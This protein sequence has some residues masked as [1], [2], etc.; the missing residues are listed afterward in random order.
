M[1]SGRPCRLRIAVIGGGLAG[2]TLANALIQIPHLEI[3]VFES[4]PTFS[5]RGA[6]VGL[7]S[8]A[9]QALEQILPGRKDDLL[10]RA[11]AVPL[12]SARSVVGSGPNAGQ[13][14]VDLSGTDPGVIVHRASLLRELVAPLP[15]KSLHTNKSLATIRIKPVTNTV[16][17]TFQDGT[18]DEFDAVIGADGIFSSVRSYVLQDDA[19]RLAASPAGFWDCRNL[20]SLE[21]AKAV[22]GEELFEVDRQYGWVGDGGFLMH[23]V[24][25]NRTMVQCV[26]S[27]VE[28]SPTR[29]RK[30][31]LTRQTLTQTLSSW[32]DGPIAKGMI[33]LALE[34][35]DL[36][37]YSQWEHKATPTYTNGL[38]CVIGDA[39]HATTPWQGSG[40]AMAFE[41]VMVLQELLGNITS[42]KDI[43]AAFKAYDVVRRPRCQRVIDSS[44]ETGMIL[45]GQDAYAGLDPEKLR[46]VLAP[47][48]DFIFGLDMSVHKEHALLKLRDILPS[49]NDHVSD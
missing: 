10:K 22:L 11:G 30:R 43:T 31:A 8:N 7:G 48:W 34:E 41:D 2:A 12:N 35:D 24:L 20:V 6:A 9:Q 17:V 16:E 39:A 13:I 42:P 47:R 3:Q 23:D 44:R 32:L 14:I 25:E 27:A 28:N 46:E 5:E 40:A 36:H 26:V 29:N 33:E 4:A 45:C 18:I 37:G 21:R 49:F 15:E 1:A 38:V 19:D